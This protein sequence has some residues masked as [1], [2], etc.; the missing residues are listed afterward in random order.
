MRVSVDSTICARH[1]Q[2]VD[3]EPRVFHFA[4]DGSLEHADDV[5]VSGDPSLAE[6]IED[7]VFLCPV[8]AIEATP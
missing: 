4:A 7:A 5:D 1:G 3:R 2:C 8:Q 6:G